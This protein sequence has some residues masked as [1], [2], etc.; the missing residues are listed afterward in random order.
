MGYDASRSLALL[1]LATS[2]PVAVFRARQE[3]AISQVVEGL[4]RLLVVQATGWGKSLVYFIATK[5]LREQG[6]GPTLLVSPLLSL[7][8][9]QILAAERMGVVAATINSD[10]QDEWDEVE[11]R[12]LRDEIDI[13]LIS[14]ERLANE[15]FRSEVLANIA[16]RI[17]L[18][19]IDEAH[20]ISDWGTISD[21]TIDSSSE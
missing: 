9:N 10:N 7:M 14:P 3:E 4:G 11:A 19:V 8:R 15:R 21:R 2:D 18:L 16:S 12:I 5:M 1:K 17:S 13:L 20:C 6:G